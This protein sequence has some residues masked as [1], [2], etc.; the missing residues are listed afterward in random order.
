MNKGI[1]GLERQISNDRIFIFEWTI[2]LMAKQTNLTANAVI[3]K[4][5]YKATYSYY[6]DI[7]FFVPTV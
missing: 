4:L 3:K 7:R 6:S 2:P 1:K 5:K